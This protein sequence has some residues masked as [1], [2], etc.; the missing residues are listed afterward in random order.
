MKPK[1]LFL[2]TVFPYPTNNGGKIKTASTLETLRRYFEID[3]LCFVEDAHEG[4]REYVP[5]DV[6]VFTEYLPITSS[7]H[8]WFAVCRL[9]LSLVTRQPYSIK[10]FYN[11]ELANKLK[12]LIENQTYDLIYVDHLAM[13][14][15]VYSM[16]LDYILD[17]H[18][19]ESGIMIRRVGESSRLYRWIWR[20]E[21]KTLME[22]ERLFCQHASLIFSI[23][24]QD[25]QFIEGLRTTVPTVVL[26]PYINSES[27]GCYESGHQAYNSRI[28]LI[29]SLH[30]QENYIGVKWFLDN[31]MPRLK[32]GTRI[33]IAGRG[34]LEKLRDYENVDFLELIDDFDSVEQITRDCSVLVIPLQSGGGIRIKALQ[35]LKAGYPIVSTS[36][37]IEGLYGLENGRNVLMADSPTEFADAINKV[38]ADVPRLIRLSDEASLWG[39]KY[40]TQSNFENI[41]AQCFPS[42]LI[43]EA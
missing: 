2:T 8:K 38:V 12:F 32:R 14:Q 9:V 22:Y 16:G 36:I 15:Y 43:S 11:K 18:N 29:G 40:Y 41:L 24:D 20:R 28:L 3:L 30:W 35:A 25:K 4:V 6:K 5:H 39:K 17:Q 10:K 13:A 26:P 7:E 27:W 1:A 37:G 23:S 19:Y 21:A 42:N 34:V 31:I 33:R